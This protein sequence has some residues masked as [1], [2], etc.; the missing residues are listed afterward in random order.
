MSPL[1]YRQHERAAN[2]ISAMVHGL[3]QLVGDLQERYGRDDEMAR[4]AEK[5][6]DE[7]VVLLRAMGE[8]CQ[9]EWPE[10]FDHDD[11]DDG[12]GK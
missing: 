3:A 6:A 8:R 10:Q 2:D 7:L 11:L 9:D 4:L 5:I 12:A 1:P